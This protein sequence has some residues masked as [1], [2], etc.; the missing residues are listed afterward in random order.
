[1]SGNLVLEEP[2]GSISVTSAALAR[3]VVRAA[4]LVDGARVRRPR[5]GVS[6]S[7]EDGRASVSLALRARYGAVL[8][9]L[10][11]AV[12]EQVAAALRQSCGVEVEAVDVAV[13][14]LD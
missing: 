4:E 2:E 9:E 1:M 14:E 13:E 8:P 11:R 5:R 12:Q 7:V 3:L 10:A 6:I